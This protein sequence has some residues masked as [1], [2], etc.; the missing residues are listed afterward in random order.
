MTPIFLTRDRKT[1]YLATK[2]QTKEMQLPVPLLTYLGP[3]RTP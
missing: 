1:S 3:R 2:A